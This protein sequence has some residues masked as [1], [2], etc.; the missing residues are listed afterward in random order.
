MTLQA[1]V[2]GD[3]VAH[4]LAMSMLVFA[5]TSSFF[6]HRGAAVSGGQES[7]CLSDA[8]SLMRP[9]STHL[10]AVIQL[11]LI[12]LSFIRLYRNVRAILL[13]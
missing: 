9:K 13:F 3:S 7:F 4:S 1:L 10:A 12:N 5:F 2:D 8:E 11:L 6:L